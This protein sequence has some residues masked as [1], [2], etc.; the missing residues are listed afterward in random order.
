MREVSKLLQAVLIYEHIIGNYDAR[1]IAT[2]MEM[3]EWKHH[4]A[5]ELQSQLIASVVQNTNL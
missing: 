3:V 5:S 4:I 1:D 2:L